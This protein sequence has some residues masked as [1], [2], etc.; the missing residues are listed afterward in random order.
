MAPPHATRKPSNSTSRVSTRGGHCES[1]RRIAEQVEDEMDEAN[2]EAE[3]M[4]IDEVEAEAVEPEDSQGAG[5][6]KLQQLMVDMVDA[7]CC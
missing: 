3:E 1:R 2:E 6:S 5:D 7:V 4:D